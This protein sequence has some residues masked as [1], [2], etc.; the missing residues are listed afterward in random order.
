VRISATSHREKPVADFIRQLLKDLP[1][2]VRE[3]SAAE[4]V[5]G[6]SGNLICRFGSGGDIMLMAHM[7]TP[8]DTAGVNP[9][10][11]EDRICS[12]GNTILGVDNRVGVTTLLR[13]LQEAS[14]DPDNY[15]DFTVAFTVC[16]ET[17]LGGSK[18]LEYPDTIKQAYA[19]DSSLRPGQFIRGSYGA[20]TWKL[21]ITGKGAHAGLAPEKG[22]NAI[23]LAAAILN[24][25][26]NGRIDAETTFNVARIEG[27]GA[28][29]VVP[30]QVTVSGE[31]RSRDTRRVEEEL[32]KAHQTVEQRVSAAGGKG[33]FSHHWVFKPYFVADDD[34]AIQL[35]NKVYEQN[36]LTPE[37]NIAAGGSDANSLNARGL[38]AVNLGVGAQNPHST[39]EFILLEDLA[40]DLALAKTLVSKDL[41]ERA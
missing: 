10:V 37:A 16:E 27:G 41:M 24:E 26:P 1:V 36:G 38:T 31:I 17:T 4:A 33:G 34:P 20:Q 9:Q 22:V 12:D 11:L 14:R 8:L 35:L 23:Q 25:F 6:N 2:A 13:L 30:D 3:D 21:L 7:D 5:Q 29:N 15:R 40:M 32:D 39:K 19:F 18:S 28:N